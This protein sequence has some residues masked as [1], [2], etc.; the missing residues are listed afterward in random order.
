MNLTDDFFDAGG[1]VSIIGLVG[2]DLCEL[3]LC[4]F[5]LLPLRDSIFK[6]AS[7]SSVFILEIKK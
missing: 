2:V 6:L 3:V 5:L 4:G 1:L 7:N